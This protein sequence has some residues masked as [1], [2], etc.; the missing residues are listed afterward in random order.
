MWILCFHLVFVLHPKNAILSQ[1]ASIGVCNRQ[2]F[3]F[4]LQYL[5]NFIIVTPPQSS[6]CHH[7]LGILDEVCTRLG[8]PL[9]AHKRDGPTPALSF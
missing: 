7:A 1:I 2:E 4:S 5:N 8:V 6:K 3:R 9:A